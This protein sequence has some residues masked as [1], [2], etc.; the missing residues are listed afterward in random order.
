MFEPSK[1]TWMNARSAVGGLW[2]C[3]L[4]A[5][6][7]AS[8][9]AAH[10]QDEGLSDTQREGR[11]LFSQ[12][13]TICHLTP[14]KGANTYGPLLHKASAGGNDDLMRAFIV[15]GTQRMPAFKFHLGEAEINA[16]IAYL[17]TRPEPKGATQ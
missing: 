12:N 17:R 13:C 6:L 16:V 1:E 2:K 9:P 11:R 5:F 3:C 10:A 4:A 14:E 15:N 8:G 7:L